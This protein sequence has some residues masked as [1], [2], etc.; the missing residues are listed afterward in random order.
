VLLVVAFGASHLLLT[1]VFSRRYL[2]AEEALPPLVLAMICL[3]TTVI[4]TMYLLAVGRRWIAWVLLL[5][6]ALTTWAVASA[7]GVPLATARADLAVQAGLAV[8]VTVGF[9]RAHQ[10]R[11]RR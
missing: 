1:L 7:H 6:A 8:V 10:G 2:G 5:G 9:V 11:L 3:S 4:L